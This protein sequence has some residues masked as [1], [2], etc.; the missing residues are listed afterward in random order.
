MTP[1]ARLQA[2]IDV[3]DGLAAT[4]LPA[5]RFL[6]DYFRARRYAGSKDRA[7]VAERVFAIFHAWYSF[8]WRMKGDAP[9]RLAIASLLAEGTAPETLFT[10]APYAPAAL[11]A[12]EI[13]AIS[14]PP[15][16]EAPL[17]VQGEFPA[18]LESDLRRAF[19]PD[20]LPEMQALHARAAI[21]LRANTLK[22]TQADLA[23]ALGAEGFATQPTPH[24][25]NGLR[26]PSGAGSANL[27]KSPLFAAGLFEFQDEAA[28]IAALLCAAKPGMCVLDF[29]AGAGGKALALAAAMENQG[30]IVARD[31]DPLRL[32]QLSPRA[33]RASATI[34]RPGAFD[35]PFDRVLLDSPC[36]GT[37]T[38]RRQPEL[39]VRLTPERLAGLTALQ[40]RLL[41]DAAAQVAPGG[42]L[43]YATCSLLPAENEDQIARFL[44]ANTAF[45]PLSAAEIWQTET[46]RPPPPGMDTFFRASPLRSGSDGFF[47]AILQHSRESA[48][49][50]HKTGLSSPASADRDAIHAREGD[51]AICGSA[52]SQQPSGKS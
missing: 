29:A 3:L 22:T 27:S 5:D 14:A 49:E 31:T 16:A 48:P 4:G 23:A 36:S 18:W 34:I 51:P 28:Q 24:A 37:G 42:R 10:G 7:A 39:R 9:R 45:A 13:S 20:L 1:A 35:G 50:S 19:G 44:A 8:A 2:A 40:A 12:E 21:D 46:G 6:R 32:S 41:E 25:P 15:C 52:R 38:W 17:H 43:V 33:L 11:T 30:E 47:T 26:L